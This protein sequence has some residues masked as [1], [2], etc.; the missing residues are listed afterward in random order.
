LA[1]AVGDEGLVD[2]DIST[3]AGGWVW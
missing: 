1:D 2:N 3:A